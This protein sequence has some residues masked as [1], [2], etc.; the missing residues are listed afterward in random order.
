MQ[1]AAQKK[2]RQPFLE[3]IQNFHFIMQDNYITIA[4]LNRNVFGANLLLTKNATTMATAAIQT[5]GSAAVKSFRTN[6]T[7]K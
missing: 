4:Y 5:Q 2:R 3:T 1:A 7:S 6:K